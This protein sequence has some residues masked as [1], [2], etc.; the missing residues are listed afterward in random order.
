MAPSRSAATSYVMVADADLADQAAVVA[1]GRIVSV[2]P[3]P[4]G[5]AGGSPS[6]DYLL[7]IDRLVKGYTAGST[8]VVRV[9]GGM[10]EDG[11]MGLEIFGAPT[12]REGDRALLF[13][14]ERPDG[15]Y[16]VLH[17]LLGAFHEAEV[18]GKR[19]V[20]R[21]LADAEEVRR[22]PGGGLA[23]APG[24]DR[25]RD[26]ERFAAWLAD[27]GRGI[28]RAP[29]YAARLAPGEL[30]SLSARYSF[31][32]S[33]TGLN[34]RWTNFDHGGSVPFFA[35]QNGQEGL[36]GGGYAEYQRALANWT[37]AAGTAIRYVYAGTTAASAGLKDYDNLNTIL[38]NDP[39]K[40]VGSAFS[41]STGG[42]RS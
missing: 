24:V 9:L 27:R 34:L 38:F 14:T 37:G 2:A 4:A 17:F 39:N 7:E 16:S 42:V 41:C 31:F 36:S 6:T 28:R 11:R 22:T 1:E 26:L 33:K 21:N 12:Y 25:P 5:P 18:A 20:L 23:A 8:I 13:L 35:N 40:E 3:S 19:V 10:P 29:D 15:S 30:A 32:V